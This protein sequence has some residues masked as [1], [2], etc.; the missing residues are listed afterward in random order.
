MNVFVN[1]GKYS[2]PFHKNEIKKIYTF[3]TNIIKI[4]FLPENKEVK[5]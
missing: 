4:T 3:S 1:I 5:Y 2:P